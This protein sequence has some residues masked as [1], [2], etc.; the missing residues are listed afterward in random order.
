MKKILYTGLM[1]LVIGLFAVLPAAATYD[2]TTVNKEEDGKTYSI[3]ATSGD[4]VTLSNIGSGSGTLAVTFKN[5]ANGSII[6]TESITRPN[7]A[8]SDTPGSLNKYY[9]VSFEGLTKDDIT[10]A[11]LSFT[12]EKTWLSTNGFTAENVV[13]SHFLGTEWEG[14]TTREIST[15]D[16]TV[17]FESDIGS[18]ITGLSHF[19]ISAVE[20]HS[21]TG[22]PAVLRVILASGIIAVVGGA[23]VIIR[24]KKK[25]S[26]VKV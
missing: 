5:D 13:L 14:H 20:S 11:V 8:T 4:K 7:E 25:A 26:Q 23:F 16:T 9:D 15:T 1:S 6:V 21:N 18:N 17:T 3:D 12:V 24:R 2:G 19:A 10:G 22:S